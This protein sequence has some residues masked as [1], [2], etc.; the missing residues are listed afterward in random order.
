MYLRG[1]VWGYI[2]GNDS[3][4]G[5]F[6]DTLEETGLPDFIPEDVK[7]QLEKAWENRQ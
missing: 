5:F 3:C 4:W 6:G 7:D 1:E 2:T